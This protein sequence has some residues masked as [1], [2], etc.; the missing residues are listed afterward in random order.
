MYKQHIKYKFYAYI[1]INIHIKHIQFPH[2][3]TY[4]YLSTHIHVI[5]ISLSTHIPTYIYLYSSTYLSVE[6]YLLWGIGSRDFRGWK[7]SQSVIVKLEIQ[8]SQCSNSIC[9][10]RPESQG[11]WW[12]K[13]QSE[14]RRWNVTADAMGQERKASFFFHLLFYA[15]PQQIGWCPLTLVRVIYF[16][17]T[18]NSNANLIQNILTARQGT[19]L[20]LGTL[21]QFSWQKISY[22]SHQEG[23]QF[24]NKGDTWRKKEPKQ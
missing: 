21:G 24:E 9:I 15:G 6:R 16:T 14:D 18:T 22:H 8:E 1:H 4:F 11:P 20:N 3:H 2:T 10:Q 12:Y 7:V 23:S 13:H 19:V 17:E 5:H